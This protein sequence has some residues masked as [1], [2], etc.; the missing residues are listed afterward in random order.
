[1]LRDHNKDADDDC[2][3]GS[4]LPRSAVGGG[5]RLYYLTDANPQGPS[6]MNVTGLVEADGSSA[7]AGLTGRWPALLGCAGPPPGTANA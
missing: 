6:D 2:T 4:D 1:V 7:R 3:D 5:E